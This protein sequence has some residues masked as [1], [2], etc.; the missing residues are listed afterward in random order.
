MVAHITSVVMHGYSVP[1]L[2]V[3]FGVG[4]CLH[5]HFAPWVDAKVKSCHKSPSVYI[6][7]VV[8]VRLLSTHA[9]L[10]HGVACKMC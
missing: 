8:S 3:A 7:K 1:W 9:V 10:C 5:P 4:V 6:C 2:C